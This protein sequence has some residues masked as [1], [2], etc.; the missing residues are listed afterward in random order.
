MASVPIARRADAPQGVR[1]QGAPPGAPSPHFSCEGRDEEPTAYPAPLKEY[2]R[3]AVSESVLPRLDHQQYDSEPLYEV[4]E[5]STIIDFFERNPNFGSVT[6]VNNVV[7]VDKDKCYFTVNEG[8]RQQLLET[9]DHWLTEPLLNTV[10]TIQTWLE[11]SPFPVP[12]IVYVHCD[13]GCDPT[14]EI[15]GG[16]MLRYM[17]VTWAQLS[18][19]RPCEYVGGEPRPLGCNNYRA[20]EWHAAWLSQRGFNVGNIGVDDAGCA[21]PGGRHWPCSGPGAQNCF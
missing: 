11:F 2:G 1:L 12:V 17:G 5:V 19:V 13:G 14:A 16:Y 15:I 7:G 3:F 6:R 21:D 20:L 9:F 10:D 18:D 4:Q 8:Q